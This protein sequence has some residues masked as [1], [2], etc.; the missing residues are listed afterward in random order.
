MHVYTSYIPK[1]NCW[2]STP[3]KSRF[4]DN[5]STSYCLYTYTQHH[6][7]P[8]QKDRK[9]RFQCPKSDQLKLFYGFFWAF[10]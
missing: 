8:P 3:T 4:I 1:F 2:T 7:V 9:S 5:L 6:L 10:L